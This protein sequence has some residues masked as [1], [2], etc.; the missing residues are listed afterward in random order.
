MD[1]KPLSKADFF[2][3]CRAHLTDAL[4]GLTPDDNPVTAWVLGVGYA[5]YRFFD[6]VINWDGTVF[7]TDVAT[8]DEYSSTD[9]KV[10]V[11]FDFDVRAALAQIGEFGN[12]DG[13][14][15]YTGLEVLRAFGQ[16]TEFEQYAAATLRLLEEFGKREQWFHINRRYAPN[17]A[18]LLVGMDLA[19]RFP[20][21]CITIVEGIR[22]CD[23]LRDVPLDF[24]RL[25]ESFAADHQMILRKEAQ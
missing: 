23:N 6:V 8:D 12:V 16:S 7:G 25:A 9:I 5:G 17:V 20:Q 13:N 19:Q 15:E 24:T 14:D 10:V 4:G 2:A 3:Y 21:S 11:Q 22:L 1:T 18:A